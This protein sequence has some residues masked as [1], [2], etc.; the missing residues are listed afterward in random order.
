[1]S[2]ADVTVKCDKHQGNALSPLLLLNPFSGLLE[3][4][5][6]GYRLNSGTAI[7]H[8]SYIDDIKLY[9]ENEQDINS[10]I[11]LTQVISSD[12]DVT[13]GLAKCG[14]LIVNRG[15]VKST[16]G[17]YLPECWIDNLDK[18]CKYI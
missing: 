12:I 13:F 8:L 14:C 1:M 9:A 7:N 3:K 6:Y 4:S 5:V 2:I 10:L 16:S 18:S 11:H 15:K 17:I